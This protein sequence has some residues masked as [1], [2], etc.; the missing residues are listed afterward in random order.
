MLTFQFTKYFLPQEQL[1]AYEVEKMSLM[2][3]SSA[4]KEEVDKL[5]QQYAQLLGHQNHKQKIH[6]VLKLKKENGQLKEVRLIQ[7]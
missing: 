7:K 3:R 5:S 4:A 2:E 6:H 1:D